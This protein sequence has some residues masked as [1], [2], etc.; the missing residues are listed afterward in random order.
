[1]ILEHEIAYK[2]FELSNIK[3]IHRIKIEVELIN[4]NILSQ[5]EIKPNKLNKENNKNENRTKF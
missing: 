4:G 5:E 1:M 3:E 2:I